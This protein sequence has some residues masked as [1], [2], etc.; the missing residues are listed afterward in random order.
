MTRAAHGNHKTFD[1]IEWDPTTGLVTRMLLDDWLEVMVDRLRSR[2][3]LYE[4]TNGVIPLVG[5]VFLAGAAPVAGLALTAAVEEYGVGVIARSVVRKLAARLSAKEVID[6]IADEVWVEARR[7]ILAIV[8]DLVV[9][10]LPTTDDL[11]TRFVRGIIHGYGAGAIDH[12]LSGIDARLE[13]E[14]KDAK[15]AVAYMVSPGATRAWQVYSIADKVWAV[16]V[17]AQAIYDAL[18]KVWSDDLPGGVVKKAKEI[19]QVLGGVVLI[20]MVVL[21]Y[22]LEM[23]SS[24]AEAQ[25]L[26]T[27]AWVEEQTK[28]LKFMIQETGDHLIEYAKKLRKVI[29]ELKSK[30][31]EVRPEHFRDADEDLAQ[32]V[33][34]SLAKAATAFLTGITDLL[35]LFLK[36]MGVSTWQDLEE[37][38]LPELLARGYDAFPVDALLPDLLEKAGESMGELLGGL[39]IQRAVVPKE[40]KKT[41]GFLFGRPTSKL[42]K[43]GLADRTWRLLLHA[44]VQPFEDLTKLP[45]RL[46]AVMKATAPD[47]A[48]QF[49]RYKPT[50]KISFTEFVEDVL[51][52]DAT[53]QARLAVL[54]EDGTIEMEL[55]T[56]IQSVCALR[57]AGLREAYRGRSRVAH[58]RHHVRA[59][60]LAA[61]GHS[62]DHRD[63]L[64]A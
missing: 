59:L 56:L 54:V 5:M 2:P 30:Q 36:R 44:L 50:K 43:R 18:E 25:R 62:R 8:V 3:D 34:A 10:C 27:K 35:A 45:S 28:A 52:H 11:A 26:K 22:M 64:Q 4:A 63:L 21:L 1:V 60:V 51:D 14:M 20:L 24:K 49:Q 23:S 42:A 12:Y 15:M 48:P 40:I 58:Q 17:R 13:R 53:L 7:K 19:S 33:K 38:R 31:Q 61:C 37:L 16:T 29:N 47:D 9:K 39:G 57:A 6:K 46:A 32:H 55:G 41:G